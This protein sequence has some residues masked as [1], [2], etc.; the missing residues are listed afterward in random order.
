V[1][2]SNVS[3]ARC[4]LGRAWISALAA[5]GVVTVA[6][7]EELLEP[8][9]FQV[10]VVRGEILEM[11]LPSE[12]FSWNMFQTCSWAQCSCFVPRSPHTSYIPR[13]FAATLRICMVHDVSP[14]PSLSHSPGFNTWSLQRC[15]DLAAGLP[16]NRRCC[17]L[18]RHSF[19]STRV[20]GD[21]P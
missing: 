15:F 12:M 4:L 2:R 19:C 11:G 1:T 3:H 5:R 13:L 10:S 21:K 9:A 6:F 16:G 8:V 17:G 14:W 7:G 18:H 20:P